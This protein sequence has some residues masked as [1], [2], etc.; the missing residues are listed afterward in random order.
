MRREP[1]G[2]SALFHAEGAVLLACGDVPIALH[3]GPEVVLVRTDLPDGMEPLRASVEQVFA[4]SHLALL[5]TE[6]LLAVPVALQMV[7]L[8]LSSWDLWGADIDEAFAALRAIAVSEPPDVIGG[9]A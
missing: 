3:I 6:T 5:D 2:Y 4:A 9:D 7:G 1:T 8:R